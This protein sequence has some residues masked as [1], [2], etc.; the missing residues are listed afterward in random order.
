MQ[1]VNS[2]FFFFLL[3]TNPEICNSALCRPGAGWQ[4]RRNSVPG[5]AWALLWRWAPVHTQLWQEVRSNVT[6]DMVHADLVHPVWDEM[7]SL[8]P[9]PWFCS[10][11]RKNLTLKY[12]AKKILYFL[13]QQ[14]ILKSLKSFLERPAEQQSPLEGVA[15]K[16]TQPK[17][18][19]T[20]I[21]WWRLNWDCLHS[22]CPRKCINMQSPPLS[23]DQP[24]PLLDMLCRC[25]AGGSIL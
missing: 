13:R 2:F 25:C 14:N 3:Q 21:W 18:H 4:L 15:W 24:S 11:T 20:L 10:H 1:P 7:K 5:D 17:L 22:S 19:C 6:T 12:Y 8:V 23:F 9:L 16:Q